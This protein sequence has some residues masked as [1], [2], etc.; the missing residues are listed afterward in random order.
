MEEWK[1]FSVHDITRRV[2]VGFVGSCENDYCNKTETDA[3][4][5]NTHNR[6]N[7]LHYSF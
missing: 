2:K 5:M 7:K 6:F 1:E 4:P 3:I